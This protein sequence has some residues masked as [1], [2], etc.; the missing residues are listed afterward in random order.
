MT[1]EDPVQKPVEKPAGEPAEASAP[2]AA[3]VGAAADAQPAWRPSLRQVGAGLAIAVL[4]AVIIVYLLPR[5]PMITRSLEIAAPPA[6]TFALV[7]DLRRFQEWAPFLDG[8][9]ADHVVFT[10]PAEGVGQTITWPG[11]DG[12]AGGKAAIIALDPGKS[13]DL[14]TDVDDTWPQ[15]MSFVVVPAG[16]GTRIV[17]RVRPDLGFNPVE[18]VT[19]LWV[20]GRVGPELEQGLARLKALAEKPAEAPPA[21]SN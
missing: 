1:A 20:D 19:G 12:M 13:V 14:T 10:G 8:E 15:L 3:A 9:T 17:W 16:E 11:I 2:Q 6:A 4:C 7:S 5:Q 18:R 21:A